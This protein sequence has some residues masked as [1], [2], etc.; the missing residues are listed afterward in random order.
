MK[1]LL[2]SKYH[3]STYRGTF[4]EE[5]INAGLKGNIGAHSVFSN[6]GR[7]IRDRMD[8]FD[9]I[10]F[11]NNAFLDEDFDY[12]LNKPTSTTKV[13]IDGI[14]D[15]FI[16]KIY[17]H[18]E[19]KYYFKREVY[20]HGF[21]FRYNAEWSVRYLYE[22]MRTAGTEGK[23]RMWFSK[24]NLP[25]GIAHVDRFRDIHPFPLTMVKPP[26]IKGQTKKE[27]DV[28]FIGHNNN[29]E[30]ASYIDDINELKDTLNL[31]ALISTQIISRNE[32]LKSLKSSKA[33][34]SL[35]GTGYD[36]WRYWEIP[37]CGAMLL[38]Q[39]L[40]VLIPNDFVDGKSALYF[41]NR[42]E[43]KDRLNR[44]VVKSNEYAEIA[45]AGREQFF[46][47]HTPEKRVKELIL[48]V[49]K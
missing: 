10:L 24:W 39:A 22:L 6:K 32:Y 31:R 49:I 3:Y 15:F 48:D 28:S 21:P 14:D 37:A 42:E 46:K 20:R 27:Y 43:L 34:L 1:I 35:R 41:R 2:Y 26:P 13:F 47:Y 5:I 29:P 30:R 7:D 19:I 17:H 45:K 11:F 16:R 8:D 40:P 33:G 25:I 36:T 18:P 44:Y 38:S 4:L 9:A 23:K 12:V